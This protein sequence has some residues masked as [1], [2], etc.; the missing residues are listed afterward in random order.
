MSDPVTQIAQEIENLE[1]QKQTLYEQF[2]QVET[3]I[4]R[5]KKLLESFQ[6]IAS[7]PDYYAPLVLS[8]VGQIYT[9][10]V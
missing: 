4:S 10:P 6:I 9:P 7:D 3:D 2:T 8:A 5:K 1:I